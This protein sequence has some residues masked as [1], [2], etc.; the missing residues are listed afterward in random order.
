MPSYLSTFTSDKGVFL[1]FSHREEILEEMS[2]GYLIRASSFLLERSVFLNYLLFVINKQYC[3]IPR[4]LVINSPTL[5]RF[6]LYYTAQ[7]GMQS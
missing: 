7:W 5:A 1:V 4:L 6:N 2:V 3:Q